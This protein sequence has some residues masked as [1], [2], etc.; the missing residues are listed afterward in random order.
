MHKKSW[1]QRGKWIQ[2]GQILADHAATV[3]LE[4]AFWGERY[5]FTNRVTGI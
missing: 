4:H 3:G 2:K 1:I 5:Y